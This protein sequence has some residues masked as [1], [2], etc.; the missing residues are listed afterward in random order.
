MGSLCATR[1]T[2]SECAVAWLAMLAIPG[3]AAIHVDGLDAAIVHT[4]VENKA[5]LHMLLVA[6]DAIPRVVDAP[7]D[8]ELGEEV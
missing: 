8:A 4:R 5:D 1:A 2:Y 7:C 3:E 6:L